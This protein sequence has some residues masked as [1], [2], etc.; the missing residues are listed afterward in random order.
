MHCYRVIY[1]RYLLSRAV[2][3][4]WLLVGASF[5]KEAKECQQFRETNKFNAQDAYTLKRN[6]RLYSSAR[7][8]LILRNCT[9]HHINT[10]FYYTLNYDK[11]IKNGWDCQIDFLEALPFFLKDDLASLEL[12]SFTTMVSI[13][14]VLYGSPE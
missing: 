6:H 1:L 4:S 10:S 11:Y 3:A 12:T 13:E 8:I 2:L 5:S 7:L 9:V 14:Q